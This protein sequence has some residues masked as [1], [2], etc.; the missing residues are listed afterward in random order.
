MSLF[1][2]FLTILFL[3]VDVGLMATLALQLARH[4]KGPERRRSHIITLTVVF[5][6]AFVAGAIVVYGTFIEPRRL[7]VNEQTL[8]LRPN[9]THTM[10]IALISDLHDGRSPRM[11]WPIIG[12]LTQAVDMDDRVKALI[13]AGDFVSGGETDGRSFEDLGHLDQPSI[14]YGVFGNHDY[15]GDAVALES[16]LEADGIQMLKNEHVLIGPSDAPLAIVGIDDLWFGA[17]DLAAATEGIPDDVPKILVAHNPDMVY[18]LG[19]YRFDAI[20]A[21]HTHGG[22]IRL[23]W[24]GAIPPLPT[25][26]G[27][28]YD[29]GVFDWQG[30]PLVITQGIGLTGP[31]ARLFAP[32]ELMILTII[33]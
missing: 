28:A 7:V 19:D 11:D 33:Y 24:I 6:L 13:I 12:A 29:R 5:F 10:K 30:M 15:M 32:P 23:P 20:L 27:K 14:T 26:L 4:I 18:A 8:T 3:V 1:F 25:V 17:P 9:G 21:G 22:Q 16:K 31:H 2:D